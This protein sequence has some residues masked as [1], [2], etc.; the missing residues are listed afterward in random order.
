MFWNELWKR[1][2]SAGS[3]PTVGAMISPCCSA[4]PSCTVTMP[5]RSSLMT[6]GWKPARSSRVAW[7]WAS[8]FLAASRWWISSSVMT[9]NSA[10]L[11]A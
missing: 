1:S 6:T 10:V 8:S 3:V 11:I 2:G 5:M 4:G 7:N 9:A